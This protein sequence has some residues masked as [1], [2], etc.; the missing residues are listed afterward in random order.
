MPPPPPALDSAEYAEAFNQVKATGGKASTVRTPEQTQIAIFWSDFSY[1]AMPPGHWHEIATTIAS[2]RKN[3]LAENARLFALL[4]MAQADAAIVCWEAKFRYN[5]WRPVTAIRRADQDDNPLTE[6]DAAWDHLLAAPPFPGYTSG[7]SAF[8]KASAEVLA[9]FCGTDAITF[10]AGSDALPGVFRT[11]HSLSACADEVGLS[12]IYGGIHFMFDNVNGKS[13]GLLIGNFVCANFLLANN[14]LPA[15]H[16]EG[17]QNGLPVVR[18]QGHFGK[19]CILEG[20]TD[21]RHWAGISTNVIAMGG[22]VLRDLSPT[23]L[24]LR[25]Y[26][27]REE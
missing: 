2:D 22:S 18:V 8:S 7:H 12:R 10:V 26:R 20:S 27:V 6:V 17:L 5:L 4:S 15:V 23:A 21:L 9:F 3:T 11:F 24:L 14:A 25:F 1:T 19:T 16:M 13:S